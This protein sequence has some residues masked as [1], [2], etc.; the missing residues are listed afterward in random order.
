[1]TAERQRKEAFTAQDY[2]EWESRQRDRHEYVSGEVLMMPSASHNH[3]EVKG[4]LLCFLN[5]KLDGATHHLYSTQMRLELIKDEHYCYP[6]LFVTC[7]PRDNDSDSEYV[8]RHPSF[9]AEI[10]LPETASWDTGRKL[11]R[12][13][14]MPSLQQIFIIDYQDKIAMLHTRMT[15]CEWA[16]TNHT[17]T[18][19]IKFKLGFELPM[20]DLFID[21]L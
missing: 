6:D 5:E 10:L 13:Q 12:Y 18:D 16:M 20:V 21:M 4:N 14:A 9:I 7:D 17:S 3:S 19:T 8:K 15:S 2:F 1:M 11:I